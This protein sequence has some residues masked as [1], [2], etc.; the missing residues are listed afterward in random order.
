MPTG[1]MGKT[2]F[3]LQ[4]KPMPILQHCRILSILRKIENYQIIYKLYINTAELNFVVFDEV[5]GR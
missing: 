3:C 5:T 4:R 1:F 2:T